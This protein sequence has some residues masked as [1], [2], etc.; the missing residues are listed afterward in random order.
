VFGDSTGGYTRGL[1][2]A[3]AWNVIQEPPLWESGAERIIDCSGAGAGA[4]T[5]AG[6]GAGGKGE[7]G[8]DQ[9]E[10]G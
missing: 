4:G 2:C 9:S 3:P 8:A 7:G 10:G 1:A 6:A 5:G